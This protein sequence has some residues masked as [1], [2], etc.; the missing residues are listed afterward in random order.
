MGKESYAKKRALVVFDRMN[1]K[2]PKPLYNFGDGQHQYIREI[3]YTIVEETIS[4]NETGKPKYKS[5]DMLEEKIT[6]I[7]NQRTKPK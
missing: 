7:T 4:I 3:L 1:D 6:N 5:R 2:I